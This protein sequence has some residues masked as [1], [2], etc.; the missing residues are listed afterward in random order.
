MNIYVDATLFLSLSHLSNSAVTSMLL[1]SLWN[2]KYQTGK[3][4]GSEILKSQAIYSEY[5]IKKKKSWDFMDYEGWESPLWVNSI[6]F[7]L[8]LWR[9][10]IWRPTKLMWR[11][12]LDSRSLMFCGVKCSQCCTLA[13]ACSSHGWE[14]TSLES[15]L[16][17]GQ[18]WW[19]Q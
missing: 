15:I 2:K 10:Q 13:A 16:D 17:S 12:G 5:I 14:H 8:F 18:L 4:L 7:Y 1:I 19:S 11:K 9:L 6:Q 3:T